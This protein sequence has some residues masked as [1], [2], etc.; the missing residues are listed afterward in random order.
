MERLELICT[1]CTATKRNSK[2]SS[3]KLNDICKT[4]IILTLLI[5]TCLET[6][7]L[8]YLRLNNTCGGQSLSIGSRNL[9]KHVSINNVIV[10]YICLRH[11]PTMQFFTRISRNTQS[12]SYMLAIIDC[13]CLGI[14]KKCIVVP[15]GG[16]QLA[17]LTN[18]DKRNKNV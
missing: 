11:S 3:F 9:T 1:K 15:G 10:N 13:L 17:K 14:P 4:V 12:K 6:G 7:F 18:K 16:G 5:V 8:I 2:E